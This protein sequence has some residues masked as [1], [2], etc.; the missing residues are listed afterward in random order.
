MDPQCR[1]LANAIIFPDCEGDLINLGDGSCDL[2]TNTETCGYDGGDCCICSCLDNSDVCSS[3]FLCV[4]PDAADELYQCEAAP[5]AVRP[6][7]VETQ[8]NWVVANTAQART[9]AEAVNC[10]NGKFSVEWRG[11]VK[12]EETIYVV[13]GTVLN[14]TGSGSNSSMDGAR[15]RRIFTVVGASLYLSD[16]TISSGS[17]PVGGAIA[18]SASNVTL[19]RT[20]FTG[21]RAAALGGALF[22]IYGSRVSFDGDISVFENNE[23]S[24][25]GG[26]IYASHGSEVSWSERTT[27]RFV[28]NSAGRHGG[29]LYVAGFSVASWTGG[30]TSLLNNVAHHSGG[31]IMAAYWSH[32][33]W[34]GDA[35]ISNNTAG[36]YGGA[37]WA[38]YASSVAWR[39]DATFSYNDVD[40][41]GG[42]VSV[43]YNS[44][45]SWTARLVFVHN[46]AG[47]VG[48]ALHVSSSSSVFWIGRSSFDRNEGGYSCGGVYVGDNSTAFWSSNT[49]FT[50]NTAREWTGGALCADDFSR[51]FWTGETIFH[52][53]EA[54]HGPALALDRN[55]A[56]SCEGKTTFSC[57]RGDL[58]IGVGG[59][60]YIHDNSDIYFMLE[61]TFFN[62]VA[63]AAGA[64]YVASNSTSSF[65]GTT[66]FHGNA[67]I[68]GSAGALGVQASSVYWGG[69]STIFS[70]NTADGSGG[71]VASVT[72]DVDPGG[73]ASSI[74]VTGPTSFVNNTSKANGG[75]LSVVDSSSVAFETMR[76]MFANN[77]AEGDGGAFYMWGTNIGPQFRGVKFLNNIAQHGGGVYSTGSGNAK[78]S[79][80]GAEVTNPT[81][82]DGCVFVGNTAIATGGA[83]QTAAGEDHML[84]SIFTENTAGVGGALRLAGTARIENCSFV[85]N[86]SNPEDGPA[87]SNIGYISGMWNCSF[88]GNSF[89]C[90]QESF[91]HFDSVSV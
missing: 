48:G 2:D 40:F 47:T 30:N 62:N 35:I 9:M 34:S 32:T 5:A 60:V 43:A 36:A 67:A 33:S 59:A 84:N 37:V 23:V 25:D 45:A 8:Q 76:V 50:N 20:S 26:A 41:F 38:F 18:V 75:A 1:D 3:F 55:S 22:V 19:T 21:N 56:V 31:A 16:V 82:F 79:L 87:V 77:S 83:I 42:A 90:A 4:D 89:S 12:I 91:L 88:Y 52:A 85:D 15:E 63:F 53:N 51:I 80:G 49:T 58:D 73:R 86:R 81:T 29:A 13:G 6:C 27:A 69:E 46:T 64:M 74:V 54:T 71:A 61:T 11:H 68:G 39:G 24:A 70:G 17:A 44:S 7:S 65:N 66:I 57:N 72:F 14:I 28:N 78:I 10:S